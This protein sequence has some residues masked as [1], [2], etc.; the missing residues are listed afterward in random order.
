MNLLLQH[1][2]NSRPDGYPTS[3]PH[4]PSWDELWGQM[5]GGADGS[6]TEGGDED[7][8]SFSILF[9]CFEVS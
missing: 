4:I 5:Q 1:L 6:G 8:L 7:L 3:Y 2:Q 9:L